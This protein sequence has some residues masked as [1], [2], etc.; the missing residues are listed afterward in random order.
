MIIGEFKVIPFA[1][2]SEGRV[3]IAYTPDKRFMQGYA[4]KLAHAV[5]G[6]VA[7]ETPK[8][9]TM[10]KDGRRAY[11]W[12]VLDHQDGARAALEELNRTLR[13]A[14]GEK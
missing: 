8:Y 12:D 7:K 6:A 1:V 3:D 2:D 11:I 9:W 13:E 10:Q 5:P 4:Q 14:A